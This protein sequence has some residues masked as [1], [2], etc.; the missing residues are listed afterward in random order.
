MLPAEAQR[1]IT[2]LA[3]ISIS[4]R[5]Y[6]AGGNVAL[7]TQQRYITPLA[8]PSITPVSMPPVT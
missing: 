6:S 8:I 1:Y 3:A 4:S 2:P 7:S 5:I